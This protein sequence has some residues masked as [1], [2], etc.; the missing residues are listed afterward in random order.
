MKTAYEVLSDAEKRA[1]YDQ[2]LDAAPASVLGPETAVDPE[3][4]K[5]QATQNFR[6]AKELIEE[7]DYHPAVEM[8]REAVR[9]VPDNAEFRYV[10]SQVELKNPN[11]IDQGLNNLKE[12]ARL[13]SRRVGLSVEA[14]RALLDHRRPHEAEPFARRAVSLDPSPENELLLQEVLD[15]VAAAPSPSP[16]SRRGQARGRARGE[17]L[18]ARRPPVP[19]S[20]APR[21]TGI[22]TG[23]GL[24]AA[25]GLNAWV[26]LLL[27]NGLYLLLPLEFPGPTAPW[28]AS[29]G[30]LTAALVLFLLEFVADKIP[31]VDHLWNVAQTLLRP[32]VGAL[33]LLSCVPESSDLGRVGFALAGA[34]A[35]L[36]THL[37]K[38]T[39]RLTSTAAT[40]GFAQIVLSLAE[41]VVAVALAALMFFVPWFTIIFLAALLLLLAAQRRRV[42]QAMAVLFFR[43]KH[44]R[45][46]LKES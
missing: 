27:F 12:A 14:A 18:P 1:L 24:A 35:T 38:S 11:W 36:A 41:D 25:A 10:L 3:M 30:V 33:L 46:L 5:K 8:L 40:R 13:D 44:P 17:P 2:S 20:P 22:L 39:T 32:V 37:A 34:A 43:L 19:L 42:F 9:F 6:R 16:W 21:L 15:V 31:I 29:H 7:K 23:L 26:I 28:L 4:R 45:R